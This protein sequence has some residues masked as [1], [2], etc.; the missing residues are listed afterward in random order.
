MTSTKISEVLYHI[1]PFQY[2]FHAT[3]LSLVRFWSTPTL[4]RPSVQT[5]YEH[6]PQLKAKQR[7]RFTLQI[8]KFM[9][10]LELEE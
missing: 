9:S 3:S 7:R 5:S 4:L 1:T 2:Q 8:C 6:H 10:N